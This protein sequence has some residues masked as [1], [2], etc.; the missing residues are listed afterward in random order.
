MRALALLLSFVACSAFAQYPAPAQVLDEA[1]KLSPGGKQSLLS[2]LQAEEKATGNQVVVVILKDLR[3]M[4]IE[5]YANRLYGAW[6]IGKRGKNNGALLLVAMKEKKLRIEVGYGLES[7]LTDAKSKRIIS[8][9]SPALGK[10]DFDS[11]LRS[12]AAQ[13]ISII[14]GKG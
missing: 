11:G 2:M 6:G 12:G 5:D 9:I 1:G 10:G 14:N 7:K 8:S 3:G 13:I 4:V